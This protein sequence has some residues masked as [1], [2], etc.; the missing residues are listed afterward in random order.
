VPAPAGTSSP[1][2][3]SGQAELQRLRGGD[4][5]R[6]QQQLLALARPTSR[7]SVQDEPESAESPTA[8]N[9]IVKPAVSATIRKS[10]AKATPH[11]AG[12]HP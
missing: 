6:Q 3:L 4:L 5:R 1:D 10:Q 8:E 2:H 11:R 7:G 12:G 9:A